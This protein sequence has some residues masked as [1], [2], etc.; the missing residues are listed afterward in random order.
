MGG[1]ARGGAR[2]PGGWACWPAYRWTGPVAR[3]GRGRR[4]FPR[5][6]PSALMP[7]TTPRGAPRHLI[8]AMETRSNG[9]AWRRRRD[10][11][12]APE[13]DSAPRDFRKPSRATR[14]GVTSAIVQPGVRKSRREAS[15]SPRL[16]SFRTNGRPRAGCDVTL[17]RNRGCVAPATSEVTNV[18]GQQAKPRAKSTSDRPGGFAW[19][20]RAAGDLPP[21]FRTTPSSMPLV[22][23]GPPRGV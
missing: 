17:P 8:A 21:I 22:G 15:D 1:R 19:A 5:P 4:G 2:R 12:R 11:N 6:A 20:L 7:A 3:S 16:R 18:R 10:L 23:R 9:F 14:K 13:P